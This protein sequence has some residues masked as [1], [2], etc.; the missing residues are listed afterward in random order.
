MP[1]T[2]RGSVMLLKVRPPGNELSRLP[3][4]SVSAVR[5]PIALGSAVSRLPS[6]QSSV[7]AVRLPIALGSAVSR[8]PSS[9]SSVK[10]VRLPIVLG[11]AVS[12]L[13]SS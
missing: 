5:L 8:L 6:S 4:K 11:S 10:A 3:D 1:R 12:W 7:K 9:Q 2:G 13:P